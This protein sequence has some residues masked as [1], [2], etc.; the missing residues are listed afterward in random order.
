MEKITIPDDLYKL[1]QKKERELKKYT[2]TITI[3]CGT[4]C[5]ASGSMAVLQALGKELNKKNLIHQVRIRATG[6]HGFCEQAPMMILEPGNIFYCHIKPEDI[7][8]IVEETIIKKNIIDKFL[9]VDSVTGNKIVKE[10]DIPFY[11]LQ[12]RTILGQNK[13][14]DPCDIAEYIAHGGYTAFIKAINELKPER[15]IEE[16]KKSGLRGRGGG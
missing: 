11:K 5:Q 7:S 16:I 13:L 6:C 3:C 10:I 4:G 14:L 2:T 8:D 9:Y 15:I 12:D 1:A